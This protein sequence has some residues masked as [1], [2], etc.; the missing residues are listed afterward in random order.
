[1][2]FCRN[3]A[4]TRTDKLKNGKGSKLNLKKIEC[5]MQIYFNRLSCCLPIWYNVSQMDFGEIIIKLVD[6][7][8]MAI[9]VTS[10]RYWGCKPVQGQSVS[11]FQLLKQIFSGKE[12]NNWKFLIF[13][14]I[15]TSEFI[16]PL[17]NNEIFK[18][19]LVLQL[20][21]G[22]PWMVTRP[23][24]FLFINLFLISQLFSTF[25]KSFT[26]NLAIFFSTVTN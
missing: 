20:R 4:G 16:L 26:N 13:Q 7:W 17:C 2:T 1:M 6:E 12:Q 18:V 11:R 21:V 23:L 24:S 14:T 8:M 19:L 25:E 9:T 5:F 3:G 15:V 22:S 10:W